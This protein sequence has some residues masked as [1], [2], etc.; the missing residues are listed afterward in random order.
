MTEPSFFCLYCGHNKPKGEESLEHA[1]PQFMGGDVAPQQYM[2]RNVCKQ[3]N[4]RL[5]LF[6]DASYAKSWFV[7]NG[8]SIAA[9]RLYIGLVDPP[10]PLICLGV[11]KIVGLVLDEG[12]VA[13][14]WIG[15]SGET[16]IWLRAHDERLHGY[17]G[18]NPIDKKKKPSTAYLCLTSQDS[19][20]WQMGIA[21]FLQMFR[22]N[23]IR[24]ILCANAVGPSGNELLP[25]F[26]TRT[27]D[28]EANVGAIMT[29]INSG[30]SVGGQIGV[31]TRFDQRFIAKMALGIGY[32]LFGEPYLDTDM[33]QEARKTCWPKDGEPGQ[34]RVSTIL[35][36][37]QNPR[38][39]ELIGYPGAVVLAVMN[40]GTSY[41]LTATVD[42]AT[43]FVV[44]L[45]PSTLPSQYINREEGY[46]LVLFPS[47]GKAIEVTLAE[48]VAH[49]SGAHKHPELEAI[50]GRFGKSL[51]FWNQLGPV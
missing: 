51:E 18:G 16:I 15:P 31:H 45:A 2:L 29:A 17:S 25:G 9:Q 49:S 32:S 13:E 38:L 24:K 11:S 30:N 21:S 48:L 50:D 10:L 12:Q 34:T 1:V 20:R 26:D 22:H 23:K 7:T 5:G 44:E 47:L 27:A 43:P 8:L 3:C 14:H 4:N 19:T 41:A 28:D 40:T 36:A 37:P 6:V 42:Q 39:S 35:G 46:A 33:A